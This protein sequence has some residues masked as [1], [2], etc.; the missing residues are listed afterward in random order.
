MSNPI[1]D[2]EGKQITGNDSVSIVGD[3]SSSDSG[4]RKTK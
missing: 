4:G 2:I 1:K 3:A